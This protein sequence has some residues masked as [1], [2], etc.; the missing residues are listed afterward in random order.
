[1]LLVE[2]FL[3]A[4]PH[5]VEGLSFDSEESFELSMAESEGFLDVFGLDQHGCR[6][7]KKWT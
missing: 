1:M 3:E 7:G 4:V 5:L 2:G 6:K